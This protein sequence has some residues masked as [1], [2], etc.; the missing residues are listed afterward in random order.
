MA[1]ILLEIKNAIEK[2]TAATCFMYRWMSTSL[3][4]N[5]LYWDII[6]YIYKGNNKVTVEEIWG[7]REAAC[8]GDNL[9]RLVH[10]GVLEKCDAREEG[11]LKVERLSI[12]SKY[13][14]LM[15]IIMEIVKVQ[16]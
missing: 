9:N 14:E 8:L 6:E 7:A 3:E 2:R 10:E 4:Q 16:S 11:G 13:L 12:T 15:D 5:G 1:D